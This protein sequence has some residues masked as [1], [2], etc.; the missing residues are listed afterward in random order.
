LTFATPSD[1]DY[2]NQCFHVS[3]TWFDCGDNSM[4]SLTGDTLF[5]GQHID[6]VD[7]EWCLDPDKGYLPLPRINFCDGIICIIPPVDDRGDINLNGI[8]NE[9]ADA[10]YYSNYF[11]YGPS[12]W[13]GE[14]DPYYP[15]KV[16]ASDVNDDGIPQTIA[17]LVYLIRIITGDAIPYGESGEGGKIAPYVNAAD[18][19]YEVN[20][21]MVVSAYSPVS[22]GGAAFVFRHTGEIGTPVLTDKAAG[23]T[24]R[25]SDTNGELRVLVFSMDNNAINAGSHDLFTMPL[26][27]NTIELVQVQMS[28]AEGNLLTVNSNKIAPPTEFALLQNY[29]NPFNAGTAIRFAL[30]VASDWSVGIY[31]VAGQLV[32]EFK[33]SNEAGMV[34]LHWDA[35][36]A[37]S[38]IYFYKLTAGDFTAN[39]KM[40]LMK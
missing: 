16:L 12:A 17:D 35:A 30:P 40:V 5:I 6:Y 2:L 33:G 3:W 25:S 29:P 27:N 38:G 11:I 37:A 23:M 4:S 19:G 26:E 8:A 13:G 7:G 21:D 20:G 32:K 24:L 1:F 39:K 10:V 22:V 36:N 14:D 15:N 9:I 31:N 28:D 18:V 34:N